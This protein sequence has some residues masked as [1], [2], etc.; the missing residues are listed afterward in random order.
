MHL[1]RQDSCEYKQVMKELCRLGYKRTMSPKSIFLC[2]ASVHEHRLDD[3][4][5]EEHW[6]AWGGIRLVSKSITAQ[7]F[8]E[9]LKRLIAHPT[10]N[11]ERIFDSFREAA[12]FASEYCRTNRCTAQVSRQGSSWT[13]TEKS[14]SQEYELEYQRSYEDLARERERERDEK[15][16]REEKELADWELHRDE[17]EKR[18]D[19]FTEK[20]DKVLTLARNGSLSY[21]QLCLVIDNKGL[22]GFTE[23]ELVEL[24]EF[25]RQVRPGQIPSMCPSCHMVGNNCTCG[26]SWF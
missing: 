24:L 20:R 4:V 5:I 25:Q 19:E 23:P 14:E 3:I 16:Q 15:R 22:Y 1:G 9:D 13:V 2:D 17:L 12:S 11:M 6:S 21:E 26:R 18:K 7:K 10:D 8:L